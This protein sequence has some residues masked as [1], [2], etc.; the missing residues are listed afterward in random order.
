MWEIEVAVVD[1]LVEV[2]FGIDGCCG[3]H[4]ELVLEV[5]ML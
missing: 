3:D 5:V 1:E 4:L 2:L